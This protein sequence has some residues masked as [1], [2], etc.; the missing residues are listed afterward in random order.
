VLDAVHVHVRVSRT[1][2]PRAGQY[3]YLSI[4]GVSYTSFVQSHPFFVSWWY[5]DAKGD[6]IVFIVQKR[7]GFTQD[8][9]RYITND[10]DQRNEMRAII[11]GLYKKELDLKSYSIILLFATGIGIASQLPYITQLLKEYYNFREKN[12]KIAV[13]WELDSE[14]KCFNSYYRIFL[15]IANKKVHLA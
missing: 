14:S 3:V 5:R 4:P 6:V 15:L 12:R 8:L 9:F 13:F 11:E 10:V 2:R 1:W 7:K